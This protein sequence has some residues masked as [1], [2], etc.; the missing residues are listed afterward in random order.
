MAQQIIRFESALNSIFVLF[1]SFVVAT[2][3]LA[4]CER[5]EWRTDPSILI[6]KAITITRLAWSMRRFP[7][8]RPVARASRSPRSH[9][10]RSRP[11]AAPRLDKPRPCRATHQPQI[12]PE[13]T[14]S[15]GRTGKLVTPAPSPV[16]STVAR[17]TGAELRVKKRET[18]SANLSSQDGSA[19]KRS[20]LE[21]HP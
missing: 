11:S 6:S 7:E 13:A 20:K 9:S 3:P 17:P 14:S 5:L 15:E 1:V 16:N 19:G 4:S 12:S 10:H 2:S 18:D 8:I 21:A